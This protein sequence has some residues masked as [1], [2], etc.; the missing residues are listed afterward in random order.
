METQRGVNK[1]LLISTNSKA[2]RTKT[3]Y[4]HMPDNDMI[5]Y[6]APQCRSKFGRTKEGE[7]VSK[8]L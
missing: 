4:S 2:I 8:E 5:S 3:V 7:S 6:L 1:V